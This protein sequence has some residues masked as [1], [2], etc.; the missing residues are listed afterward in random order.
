[1]AKA[2]FRASGEFRAMLDGARGGGRVRMEAD[3]KVF[4]ERQAPSFVTDL[5]CVV[6]SLVAGALVLLALGL[7]LEELVD[8][9]FMDRHEWISLVVGIPLYSVLCGII[10]D[11]GL[12]FLRRPSGRIVDLTDCH[13]KEVRPGSIRMTT[14]TGPGELV[15]LGLP[16]HSRERLLAAPGLSPPSIE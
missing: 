10:Y 9:S 4:F 2:R 8:M 15:L 5:A 12:K 14:S 1:M 3:G 11:L 16:K 6:M 13:S 7:V